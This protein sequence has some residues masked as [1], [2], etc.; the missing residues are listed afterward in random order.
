MPSAAG[1]ALLPVGGPAPSV[2]T[3]VEWGDH[4]PVTVTKVAASPLPGDGRRCAYV[5]R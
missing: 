4:E 1:Y 5:T 2:G 3:V